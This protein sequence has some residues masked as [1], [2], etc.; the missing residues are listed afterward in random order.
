M[1]DPRG[2]TIKLHCRKRP[3]MLH[4]RYFGGTCRTVMDVDRIILDQSILVQKC[5]HFDSL[6]SAV[7]T[8]TTAH[9]R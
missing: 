9:D 1:E 4:H 3:G 6:D 8:T 7:N 2:Y 5:Q